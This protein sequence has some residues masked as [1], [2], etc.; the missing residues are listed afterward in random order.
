MMRWKYF[1]LSLLLV[2]PGCASAP[3]TPDDALLKTWQGKPKDELI[4]AFGPPTSERKSDKGITTLI[5]ER[6]QRHPSGI[7]R[8]GMAQS[9]YTV[10]VREFEIDLAG[11]VQGVYQH[12]CR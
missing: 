12:N 1:L 3:L 2:I 10:C 6:P 8:M 5:W 7:G 9:Y 4:A 11:L